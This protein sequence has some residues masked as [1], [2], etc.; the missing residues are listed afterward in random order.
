MVFLKYIVRAANQREQLPSGVAPKVAP[1]KTAPLMECS[2]DLV[3]CSQSWW[4][5]GSPVY[6]GRREEA[7]GSS[8]AFWCQKCEQPHCGGEAD[9][10]GTP[11]ALEHLQWGHP[12]RI[13]IS[14]FQKRHNSCAKDTNILH[15]IVF[16]NKALQP[17]QEK[18]DA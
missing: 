5:K 13:L 17:K 2:S 18:S 16:H 10:W 3:G 8:R 1:V 11:E 6:G 14:S 7:T 15:I 4:E 9:L 12:Q